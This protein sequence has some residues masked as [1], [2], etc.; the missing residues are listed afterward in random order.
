[1]RIRVISSTALAAILV[2]LLAPIPQST[3]LLEAADNKAQLNANA[4]LLIDYLSQD[5]QRP[6][7]IPL[8]TD[9]DLNGWADGINLPDIP[10][11]T[12]DGDTVHT[13]PQQF[14]HYTLIPVPSAST[15]EFQVL[16]PYVPGSGDYVVDPYAPEARRIYGTQGHA[17]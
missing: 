3:T 5:L 4:R 14:Q 8:S 6:G 16:T 10:S 13:N 15:D 12:I 7:Y 2:I 9:R 11:F 1:M 17:R